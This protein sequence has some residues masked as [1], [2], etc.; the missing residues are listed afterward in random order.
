MTGSTAE[1]RQFTLAD[2]AG[3]FVAENP[4]FSYFHGKLYS[5]VVPDPE[6]FIT[7]TSAL[8][9]RTAAFPNSHPAT[10]IVGKLANC[11]P[12]QTQETM[13]V[14]GGQLK[15]F[16]VIRD[17]KL[18]DCDY[19]AI[20][21]PAEKTDTGVSYASAF[22]S[23]NFLRSLMAACFGKLPFYK[24]VADFD[25]D[26]MGQ[27]ATSSGFMRLPLY[28]D[29]FKIIDAALVNEIAERLSNQTPDYRS[30]LQHA[31]N[32]F[33]LALD[34]KDEAF[35]FSSYW[36]ALEIV[37]GGK[38]GAIRSKLA[39]A[40]GERHKAF[41]DDVLFFTEI[42]GIRHNLIH[43]GK[44]ATLKSY[45]ERLLQ[46]YFWDIVIYQIGLKCRGLARL[47]A[48]SGMIEQEIN[49]QHPPYPK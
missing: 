24:W 43:G 45:Q 15:I 35:R 36:I 4:S 42:E 13:A 46:L 21:S 20:I 30:R 12:L 16:T 38:S 29:V 44:F 7:F 10:L 34:Q 25:F 3:W 41:A 28:G 5:F 9:I 23:I 11:I 17:T 19:L 18:P 37:V 1:T 22:G 39:A 33:D 14:E 48:S 32:F 6:L 26:I 27:V 40:Y 8:R 49:E 2:V 31:S 47:F